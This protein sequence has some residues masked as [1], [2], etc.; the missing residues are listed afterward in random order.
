MKS[1]WFEYKD[2]AI[3]L[4]KQGL[5][6]REIENLLS[7]P[8]S[9][10]SGWLRDVPL[11]KPQKMRLKQNADLALV[12]ARA[13][14]SEWHRSQKE[15]RLQKADEDAKAILEHIKIDDHLVELALAMLYLGEGAKKNTTAIGNSNPLILKFFL[16]VLLNKYEVDIAKIKCDL[17]I[18]ADQ[19]PEELKEYWSQELALPLSNFRS[20]IVDIRTTGRTSYPTY[21]GVCL[22]NCGNI[23]IQRKLISLYNQFCQKVIDEWAISSVG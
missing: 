19:D 20:V 4:R 11:S 7:I 3:S 6:V 1:Q 23:A 12:K 21:K 2:K 15:L 22:V 5:S 16:S 14:A 8:R 18:R 17:H 13:K 9:T 10:L